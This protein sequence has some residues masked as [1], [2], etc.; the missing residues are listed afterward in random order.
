MR[1][2]EILETRAFRPKL[3]E[4]NEEFDDLDIGKHRRIPVRSHELILTAA[5]FLE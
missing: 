3:F 4:S 5:I 2:R 1:V